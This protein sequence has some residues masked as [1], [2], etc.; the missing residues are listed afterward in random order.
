MI[1]PSAAGRY[2]LPLSGLLSA[3]CAIVCKM[4][5]GAGTVM[6]LAAGQQGLRFRNIWASARDIDIQHDVGRSV[7]IVA[8]NGNNYATARK[9][10]LRTAPKHLGTAC[11]CLPVWAATRR[12]G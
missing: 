7:T 11:D 4:I 8:L 6:C 1:R 12:R 3:C 9:R 10:Q 2:L 5:V